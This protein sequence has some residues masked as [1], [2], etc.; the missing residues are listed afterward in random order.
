MFQVL[1]LYVSMHLLVPLHARHVLQVINVLIQ[2]CQLLRLVQMGN[3]QTK[4]YK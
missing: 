3:T 4:H 1:A 2:E